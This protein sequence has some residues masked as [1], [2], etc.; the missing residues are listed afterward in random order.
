MDSNESMEQK[1]IRGWID[2]FDRDPVAIARHVIGVPEKSLWRGAREMM[3]SIVKN[4][5]TAVQAGHAM[6]KDWT[7]GL[8]TIIWLLMHWGNGKVIITAPKMDQVKNIIFKEIEFQYARLRRRD[9]KFPKDAL[10]TNRLFFKT[11]C[12][13]L[14]MTTKENEADSGDASSSKFSGFHS[15]N[16]LI[17]ISESQG[18][19]PA[20]YKQIRGLMTSPNCRLL[21]IGNPV[22]PFGDFYDH[23]TDP[24][25]GYNVIHLPATESP[26]I[27]EGK[28]VIP[29]MASKAWLEEFQRDYSP[30]YE[31]DP[32]YQIRV[33]ALFPQQASSAWIPLVKIKNAIGR[34][35]E[36]SDDVKVGGLDVAGPGSDESV[37]CTLKGPQMLTQ[38]PFRK[39]VTDQIVGWAMRII[40]DEKL[41]LMAIDYGYDPGVTNWLNSGRMPVMGVTFGK[42]KGWEHPK[43]ENFGTFMWAQ[44]R[45]AFMQDRI[46]IINDPM[47]ISQLSSRRIETLPNGKMKLQSKKASGLKSPDRADALAL[48]WHARMR[49]VGDDLDFADPGMSEAGR[50]EENVA[51]MSEKPSSRLVSEEELN[52]IGAIGSIG[53]ESDNLGIF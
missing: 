47:L 48:A 53:S 38:S 11:H 3:W 44:L 37:F 46:G 34:K 21:E 27:V 10:S 2:K 1:A 13:A 43:Y 16:L 32:Q 8:M 20:I 29:G 35:F 33:L 17:I 41:E 39:I 9:P 40:Q 25:K 36:G 22:L 51:R 28:E 50:L 24:N 4:R 18:I 49:L 19:E 23:C 6:S 52:D 15:P 31:D 7:A 42:P 30:N 12:W 5:K 45:D 14:G 26:N